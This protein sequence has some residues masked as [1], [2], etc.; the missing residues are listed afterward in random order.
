[1]TGT[2]ILWYGWF[3]F[4]GGSLGYQR[5][6][7]QSLR[8]HASVNTLIGGCTGGMIVHCLNV[9][10]N[11]DNLLIRNGDDSGKVS[12]PY[13]FNS[14]ALGILGGLVA[15]TPCGPFIP[16]GLLLT[17]AL[18][19]VCKVVSYK[20]IQLGIDDPVD[21]FPTHVPAAIVGIISIGFLQPKNHFEIWDPNMH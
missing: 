12:Q 13:E 10:S 4:N 6:F 20:L 21:A 2:C 18:G 7:E 15:V 16:S 19:M 5:A 8:A 17:A 9:W 14:L 3:S 11:R 1:M